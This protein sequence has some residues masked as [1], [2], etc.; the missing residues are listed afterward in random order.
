GAPSSAYLSG[1]AKTLSGNGV[2]QGNFSVSTNWNLSPGANGIGTLTFSNSL[3]LTSGAQGCTN[4]FEISK[5]P[6]T[7]DVAKVFG[8]LTNGGTLIVT[9]IGS[10]ALTNG[11]SFR[12]FDAGSY[13]GAF[14]SVFLPALS[15]GLVWNTNSLNTGGTV[16]VIELTSPTISGIQYGGSD[17]T[18]SGSG[19]VSG[20]PYVVLGATNVASS[21][22]PVATNYFDAGGNFSITLTNALDPNQP[23]SFYKL[24]VR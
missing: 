22:M 3:S 4:I 12:L 17:L 1:V 16:S 15:P 18:I 5:S 21:W 20:W 11:D 24:Q 9:N 13:N 10:T 7:N 14:D 6:L 23:Q 8:A 19:G 2:I